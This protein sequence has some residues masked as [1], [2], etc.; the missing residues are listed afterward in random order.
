MKQVADERLR[1]RE[2][3]CVVEP[4]EFERVR[5]EICASGPASSGDNLLGME[6]DSCAYLGDPDYANDD[7]GLWTDMTVRRSGSDE[8]LI[9]GRARGRAGDAPAIAAELSR[10]WEQRLRYNYRSA[11]TVI[12]APDS[13]TLRAVTQIGPHDTWVTSSVRVGL[14]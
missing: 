5:A 7:P 9:T 14:I 8:W 12:S 4:A 1:V 10:I 13:V 11:H 6:I 2:D 3:S